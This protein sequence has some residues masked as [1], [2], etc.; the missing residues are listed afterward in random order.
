M[1]KQS[2]KYKDLA[3]GFM[4]AAQYIAGIPN[5]ADIWEQADEVIRTHLNAE[6]VSFVEQ[7]QDKKLVMLHCTPSREKFC[8]DMVVCLAEQINTVFESGFIEADIFECEGKHS[9]VCMPIGPSG[10]VKSVAL[11][12][13]PGREPFSKEMLDIYLSLAGLVSVAIENK[14]NNAGLLESEEKFRAI[15]SNATDAIIMIDNKGFVTFWNDAAT[16]MFGYSYEEAMGSF[17]HEVLMLDEHVPLF[18]KGFSMFVRNGSGSVFGRNIEMRTRR[19]SGEEF[20][21]ELSISRVRINNSWHAVGIV[22]DITERK[23]YEASLQEAKDFSDTVLNSITN[24]SIV[25]I[26]TDDL[27][28]RSANESY[29]KMCGLTLQ[30]AVGMKCFEADKMCDSDMGLCP[31]KSMMK[32]NKTVT[33]DH[34]QSDARGIVRHVEVSAS[35][36]RDAQGYITA[37]VIV[38]RDITEKKQLEEQ[39]RQSQKMEA[40]GLLAGGIA[41]DFNNILTAIMGY[42]SLVRSNLEEGSPLLE[43]INH[44]LSSGTKAANLIQSLMAFSR[45][46]PVNLRPVDINSAITKIQKMLSR[47]LRED[48]RLEMKLSGKQAFAMADEGQLDQVLVNFA[49]NARDAMPSGGSLIIETDLA[50]VDESFA[51][52]FLLD[53]PGMYVKITISDT[54]KGIEKDKMS[55]IFEPFFTT[56]PVGKGTGLGL[57]IVFGIIKQHG[58]CICVESEVNKGTTFTVYLPAVEEGSYIEHY[59]QEFESFADTQGNETVLVAE[60]NFELRS[61]VCEVLAASGYKVLAAENGRQVVDI[62]KENSGSVDLLLL[63]VL[64]PE[65]NGKEAYDEIYRINGEIKTIFMSGYTA[66]VIS[67]KGIIKGKVDFMQKPLTP[68]SL[69]KKVRD[70]LDRK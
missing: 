26:N 68:Y 58:G 7:E 3:H 10:S 19:K 54:G 43:H 35:P 12:S 45:K 6:S 52:T 15:A 20:P 38:E 32:L 11:I 8:G 2:L 56:K 24:E 63:D 62:Y 39:L 14:K 18:N 44:I 47:L 57:A 22:R 25:I 34:V 70:V 41:H 28:I 23:K 36:V 29:L 5:N 61:L 69:L 49:T 37:A 40:V 21:V 9:V 33:C 4:R 66:D 30:D 17:L 64:M 65:M 51:N 53:K 48:I 46:Q 16:A 42:G 31:L 50:E 27:T 60:D 13:Y 67:Q 59:T 1:L 55:H